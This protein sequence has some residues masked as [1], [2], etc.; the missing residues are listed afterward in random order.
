MEA[1]QRL[2]RLDTYG[3]HRDCEVIDCAGDYAFTGQAKPGILPNSV[4]FLHKC[5]KCGDMQSFDK[6]FPHTMHWRADQPLPRDLQDALDAGT[7]PKIR[8]LS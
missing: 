6:Q 8:L 1:K 4:Q 5:I 7:G 2:Y 3:V